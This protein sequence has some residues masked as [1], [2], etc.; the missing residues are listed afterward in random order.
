VALSPVKTK[1]LIAAVLCLQK[2]GAPST[3][4]KVDSNS[5]KTLAIEYLEI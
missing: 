4:Y 5:G 2:K 3:F 1:A